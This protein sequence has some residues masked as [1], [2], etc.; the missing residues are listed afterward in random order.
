MYCSFIID[1]QPVL[2]GISIGTLC[3]NKSIIYGT[4]NNPS[5]K[6]LVHIYN[7]QYARLILH[8]STDNLTMYFVSINR[9]QTVYALI[10]YFKMLYINAVLK[11][12]YI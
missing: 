10:G 7:W 5:T 3:R 11:G 9:M 4:N 8:Q 6:G 1:R 12:D 2:T